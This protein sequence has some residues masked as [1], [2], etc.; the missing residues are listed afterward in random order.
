MADLPEY[1]GDFP[2]HDPARDTHTHHTHYTHAHTHA[3]ARAH[4]RTHIHTRA[5]AQTHT[6][7]R[8][9][10]MAARCLCTIAPKLCTDLPRAHSRRLHCV[11]RSPS[12]PPRPSSAQTAWISSRRCSGTSP[13]IA[14]LPRRRCR[15]RTSKSSTRRA[16]RPPEAAESAAAGWICR[17][18][19]FTHVGG[20][21]WGSGGSMGAHAD[22]RS[23]QKISR[24]TKWLPRLPP[25]TS[26]PARRL[27][28]AAT[29]GLR[30]RARWSTTRTTR[31][32][33]RPC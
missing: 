6:R 33:C 26:P 8:A 1:R 28:N 20:V 11:S 15:T 2:Q 30:R 31:A 25:D 13:A 18:W 10:H 27:A 7:R 14:S 9:L 3:R 29:N 17:R 5:R 12:P 19:G 21:E 24:V 16:S 23:F 32:T 4:T 22:A